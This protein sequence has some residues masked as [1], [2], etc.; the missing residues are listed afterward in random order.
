[1][2]LRVADGKA[3]ADV[4]AWYAGGQ[5]GP[6]PFDFTGGVAA[7]RAGHSGWVDL[8]L[9]PGTYMAVC[10]LPTADG[11]PHALLGM[12]STFQVG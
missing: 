3:P 6:Q 4:L 10:F 8:D 2:F 9:A 7:V 5:V 1:V 11:T 12:I